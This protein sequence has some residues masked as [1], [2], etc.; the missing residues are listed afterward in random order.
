MVTEEGGFKAVKIPQKI[1]EERI[2]AVQFSVIGRVS[3]NKGEK[4]WKHTD[5]KQQLNQKWKHNLEWKMISLGKG[6]YQFVMPN[7]KALQVIWEYG[8]I[9]LRPGII[10]FSP[11]Y[12]DFNPDLYKSTSA[13]VWVRFYNLPWEFWDTRIIASIARAVGVPIRFDNNTVNGEFGHY[14]RVLID[15]ELSM[16][17][18]DRLQVD[19]E[20]QKHWVFLEYENL[21]VLCDTCSS[22]GHDSSVCRRNVPKPHPQKSSKAKPSSS[23]WR[24]APPA[25]SVQQN[26]AASPVLSEDIARDGNS[27]DNSLQVVIH[28]SEMHK[29]N[30]EKGVYDA[31]DDPSDDERRLASN[32]RIPE[33]QFHTELPKGVNFLSESVEWTQHMIRTHNRENCSENEFA[34]EG[35]DWIIARKKAKGKKRESRLLGRSGFTV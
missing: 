4:P 22:I 8:A 10:R 35:S 12:P 33:I 17:I 14:A 7:E 3:L 18:Q 29:Q 16:N 5:L 20:N 30:P 15:V 31:W 26:V 11:W 21:P 34:A 6:F 2:K 13:Q 23:V 24:R 9:S 25:D 32:S 28:H 27:I 19:T 1:Y